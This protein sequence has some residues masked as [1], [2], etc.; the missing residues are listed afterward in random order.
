[1]QAM[2]REEVDGLLV[3]RGFKRSPKS[4]KYKRKL[5][6]S[7]H[8]ISFEGDIHPRYHRGA[9]IHVYPKFTWEIPAVTDK[10]TLLLDNELLH[11][12]NRPDIAFT[13]PMD[14]MIPEGERAERGFWFPM[15]KDDYLAIGKSVRNFLECRILPVL[16]ELKTVDDL[17]RIY[18]NPDPRVPFGGH[19]YVHTSAAYL[20]KGRPDEALSVMERQFSGLGPRAD[21]ASVFEHIREFQSENCV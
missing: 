21:F 15:C 12:A 18:E 3:D 1:M 4:L 14:H 10:V 6:E 8:H 11:V 17:I 9:E 13:A 5:D 20:L 19:N 16:E 2:L 7:I